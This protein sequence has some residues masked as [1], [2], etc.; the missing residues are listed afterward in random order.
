MESDLSLGGKVCY[1][2]LARF[3]GKNGECW[4]TM[5]TIGKRIGVSDRQ[6][7]SYVAE[8]VASGFITRHRRGIGRSNRYR[9]L[10]HASFDLAGEKNSSPKRGNCL[11]T[12]RGSSLP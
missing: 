5:Q 1:G 12:E 11:P 3:A 6:A 7:K 10:P 8:L 9:F 2:V 4:P